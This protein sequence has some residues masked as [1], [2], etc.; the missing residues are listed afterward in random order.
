MFI[1][2]LQSQMA[3]A[4]DKMS[5]RHAPA[6]L[7]TFCGKAL[8]YAFVFCPGIADIL[9]RLWKLPPGAI[10][11]IL[12]QHGLSRNRMSQSTLGEVAS[13]F[14]PDFRSISHASTISTIKFLQ[15]RPKIPLSLSHI[16]WDQV[17]WVSRWCGRE[18]YLFFVFC[19]HYYI[20]MAD[21]L[22]PDLSKANRTYAPGALFVSAQTLTIL[23]GTIHRQQALNNGEKPLPGPSSITFDDVL[24]EADAAGALPMPAANVARPMA[25][26]RLIMLLRDFLS[27]KSPELESARVIF[28][29]TF[30]DLLEASTKRTSLFDHNA[31]YTLCDFMEE[32]IPILVRFSQACSKPQQFIDWTFW[33]DV[34]KKIVES[35]NTLS[36]IRLLAFV[37]SIWSI[38][39]AD[40]C[41]KEGLC[42]GWLLAEE[43]FEKFF[44]H[45][46]PMVRT[47]FM[48]LLCWR[49]A[50]Y[51]GEATETDT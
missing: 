15:S 18:S 23:D 14:P 16:N 27:D 1:Q 20:L 6:S 13:G 38:I 17:P 21:F 32:A 12:D 2:N 10:R 39:A 11:R 25:E 29:E 7:V 24:G 48:R 19:K 5:L 50:R 41:R 34:C 40:D 37:Y 35:Q 51:D 33:L 22:P 28:A 42:L 30:C 9:I 26:N 49:V 43:T 3:F 4:I 47:Y 8:A 45:W 44:N 31:C 36:E 46:C